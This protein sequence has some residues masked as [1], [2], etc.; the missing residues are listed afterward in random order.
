MGHDD[1]GAVGLEAGHHDFARID[2]RSVDRAIE[3][4]AEIKDAVPSVQKQAGEDLLSV[5]FHELDEIFRDLVSR[6]HSRAMDR[7]GEPVAVSEFKGRPQA[8]ICRWP[9]TGQRA[10]FPE[11]AVKQ[12]FRAIRGFS[13]VRARLTA[14]SPRRP[15]RKNIA[16]NSAPERLLASA[17]INFSRGRSPAGQ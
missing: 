1:G 10:E 16:G 12:G 7:V 11:T 15:E 14:S 4:D 17:P 9:A 13:S 8:R 2:R 5:R 6:I 3:Q